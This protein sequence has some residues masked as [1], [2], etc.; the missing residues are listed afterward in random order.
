[1]GNP[2]VHV[3]VI[4][5]NGRQHLAECFD[6]LLAGTYPNARFVLIDNASDDG[7][8]EF[9]REQYGHDVRVE[10]VEC[11]SNLGWSGGNNVG[12]E[13]ALAAGADYAF[14][15]NND[16]VTA[17]DA[18]AK[19]VAM[20]ENRPE[21]GALAPKMVLYDAP[22]LLNS[23]GVECS[24][25]GAGWDR[26]LGRVDGPQWDEPGRV[27]GVCGGAWWIRCAVLR[28]TGLLPADFGI[29]LD[30]LDLC[31]R[32][33][34]AGYSIETCPQAIVRHK[35]SATMGEGAQ[36]RRK[37]YLNTRNRMR[38][39][40]RNWPA[41]RLLQVAPALVLG[42]CRAVG[43]ALLDGEPWR[44]TAH[45]RAW[46]STLAYVPVAMAAR[47][48]SK[49]RGLAECRFWDLLRTDH[50]FF[51][52]IPLPRDGWYEAC[53][54]G[55]H[56]VRPMSVQARLQVEAG[57]L[58]LIHVNRY[59]DVMRTH[60]EVRLDGERIGVLETRDAGETAIDVPAAGTLEFAAATVFPAE[61]TGEP[62]DLGG[63]VAV[64]IE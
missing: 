16:T 50:L 3:L 41:G 53:R 36:L 49:R 43:R 26:G 27:L 13:R 18:V 55:G 64:E 31:L 17:P 37:Y 6:S 61:A 38:L 54:V 24:L 60:I 19:L 9:V 46:L 48:D 28:K 30:D 11:P 59:P 32:I 29:Y 7:S 45:L 34:N 58:R 47:T 20:A 51:P 12:M 40:M 33:W 57:K 21:T 23:L 56:T 4:N 14:L 15:L 8:V 5:W 25:I 10:I 2:L 63:W 52:G 1:M 42:E 39:V 44:A 62:V 35:F 22:W